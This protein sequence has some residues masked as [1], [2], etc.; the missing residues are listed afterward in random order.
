MTTILS[1][2]KY[3]FRMLAKRPGFT[4]TAVMVLA[5]G[6][7]ANTALFSV[8]HSV[9]LSPL[10]FPEPHDLVMLQTT[11]TQSSNTT[12][13]SGPDYLDWADRNTVFEDLC[14]YN[15]CALSLTGRGNP[16]ALKGFRTT[17]SFTRVLKNKMALGVGFPAD[18]SRPSG[19]Q[20]VA[21][22]THG[23][24]QDRFAGD[25]NIVGQ[26]IHLDNSQYAVIGITA[27]LQGFIEDLVQVFIPLSRSELAQQ[28][29][30]NRY[31][32]V[33]GR[34]KNDVT[35]TQAQTAMNGLAVMLEKENPKSNDRERI[36]MV[37]L[38]DH[39]LASLQTPFFILYGAVSLLLLI[40]C[41]N[42][43]NLIIAQGIKRKRE[44]AIRRSLGASQGRV[45]RQL[46]TENILLALISGLLG[47]WMAFGGLSLLQHITP[48]FQ[49][50]NSSIPG[51]TEIQVNLPVLGFTLLISL[52]TGLVFGLL[53]AW[54]TS[55]MNFN[56]HLHESRGGL[57]Q[58]RRTHF[59]LNTLVTSQIAIALI[60]LTAS[61]LLIRS[62]FK[63]RFTDPG[64]A[65]QHILAMHTVRPNTKDY[66]VSQSVQFFQQAVNKLATLSGVEAAG[67]ISVRP[68][69]HEHDSSSVK[70]MGRPGRQYAEIRIVTPD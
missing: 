18:A 41:V 36:N 21:I 45:I 70:I 35:W 54:Q 31:L 57:S 23:L 26:A 44:I 11:W 66:R 42:V 27:P 58:N 6:I 5:L 28:H 10:P 17:A 4:L 67:A 19:N 50:A 63:L 61:G 60:L 14:A 47:L 51:F 59:A 40:A 3:S 25:P 69:S 43:A 32:Q 37:R 65:S 48:H 24:W 38:Q 15:P 46:I 34:L 33:I 56:T 30:T 53:P 1:D 68:L 55:R 29:R 39:I 13:A 12:P 16:T 22:L 7:G 9:L 8:I 52:L 64:F 62:F 2:I 49:G 20:N